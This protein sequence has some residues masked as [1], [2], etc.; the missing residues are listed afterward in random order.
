MWKYY[1]DERGIEHKKVSKYSF[2]NKSVSF[3][4]IKNIV[5]ISLKVIPWQTAKLLIC[6]F[7]AKKKKKVSVSAYFNVVV[8]CFFYFKLINQGYFFGFW[9]SVIYT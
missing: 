5:W 3:P 1:L 2:I 6:I 7:L 9:C 4:L 8:G